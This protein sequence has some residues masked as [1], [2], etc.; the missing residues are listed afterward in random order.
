MNAGHARV[1]QAFEQFW[2]KCGCRLRPRHQLWAK[3]SDLVSLRMKRTILNYF[4][5]KN[6]GFRGTKS[7]KRLV[8]E[9]QHFVF[10]LIK[11]PFQY[12]VKAIKD[13]FNMV[14]GFGSSI[15]SSIFSS[16]LGS[17]STYI[18]QKLTPYF[19]SLKRL[20]GDYWLV[21]VIVLAS[22]ETYVVAKTV[23]AVGEAVAWIYSLFRFLMGDGSPQ[24]TVI[25]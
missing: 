15:S 17:Y 7:F 11:A 1:V 5:D 19:D 23:S 13:F 12:L 6:S 25:S 8:V 21:V 24:P 16:M 2:S 14:T 4:A 3:C 9:P 18:G 20:A 10:D 22:T